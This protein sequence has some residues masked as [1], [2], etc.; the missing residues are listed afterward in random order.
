ML[1]DPTLKVLWLPST[2]LA[3]HILLS[4]PSMILAVLLLN[5]QP[6]PLYTLSLLSRTLF[7]C[8]L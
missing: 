6:L 3:G 1:T 2:H 4:I 7:L 5:T 8:V